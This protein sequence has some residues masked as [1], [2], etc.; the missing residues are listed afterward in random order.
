MRRFLMI[1]LVVILLGHVS[2]TALR[3][4]E[5]APAPSTR[6]E[7]LRSFDD[8]ANK[9]LRLAEAIP[10]D[11]YTWRPGEGVRSVSEAFL[12][13]SAGNF[14]IPRRLGT[15]PP[16]GLD[17]RGLEKSST[18]KAKVMETLKQSV[19]NVRAAFAKVDDMEKTAQWFGNRQAS[20]REIMF[21]IAAHNHE[22]LGQMI[23]YARMAGITPPW[24]E[25]AQQRQQQP[26]KRPQ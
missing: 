18:E 23:A 25:E 24:T 10:A 20:M 26:A 19:E 17:I 2:A 5:A 13:V 1:L 12:H 15:N 6:D 4:Q 3:A 9:L 16:E 11:K 7:A 22:H 8:A 21:F 14:N